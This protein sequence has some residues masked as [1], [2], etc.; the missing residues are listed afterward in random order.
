M[1]DIASINR[2]WLCSYHFCVSQEITRGKILRVSFF[3][4]FFLDLLCCEVGMH[5]GMIIYKILILLFL[6]SAF[7]GF[8]KSQERIG[9][10][11]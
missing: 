9:I 11:V 1:H 5:I 4:S 2:I 7:D 8:F 10:S 6:R 3:L